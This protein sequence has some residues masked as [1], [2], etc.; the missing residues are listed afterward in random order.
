MADYTATGNLI[1][2]GLRTPSGDVLRCLHEVLFRPTAGE[3]VA[4]VELKVIGW[5]KD[6]RKGGG[7]GRRRAAQRQESRRRQGAHR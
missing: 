2:N 1:M 3:L 4:P 7:Q 5:K 6:D